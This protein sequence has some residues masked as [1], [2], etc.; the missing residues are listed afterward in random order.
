M[1]YDGPCGLR[2]GIKKGGRSPRFLPP[3]EDV[4][5]PYRGVKMVPASSS[6]LSNS[7]LLFNTLGQGSSRA[8]SPYFKRILRAKGLVVIVGNELARLGALQPK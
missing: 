1:G 8:Q 4:Q 2:A 5:A 7:T 3:N 6:R